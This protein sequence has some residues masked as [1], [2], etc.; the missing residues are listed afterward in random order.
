MIFR[1]LFIIFLLGFS[2]FTANSVF[3][4][5]TL[6]NVGIIRSGIWYSKD[7][8]YSGD[9]VRI[10]TLVFNGGQYDLMGEVVFDDNG[11]GICTGNFSAPSGRTQEMWCDWTATLGVH[12]ISAKIV[13]PKIA[14][15]G[16]AP[17]AILL[18]NNISGVSERT[19][20]APPKKEVPIAT[21]SN[22]TIPKTIIATS[23]VP[24]SAIERGIGEG[25][26][27][28]KDTVF[29]LFPNK[30]SSQDI[31]NSGDKIASATPKT[32][33]D[34]ISK[35]AGKIGGETVKEPIM[36]LIDF[37]VAT[38]NFVINDPLLLIFIV[39][40]VVWKVAK[41]IYRKVVWSR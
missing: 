15:I 33:R 13:N 26:D 7:P 20:V 14:P 32:I 16:E 17:R 27:S 10:Y 3:A 23:S 25:L 8:F 39:I 37:F 24:G 40:Y 36:H 29:K 31:V 34:S 18:E 6:N 4:A 30:I 38:Y 1:K 2:L 28:V 5:E 21:Q 12:K 9:K 19:V 41:Y 35:I 11:K 22:S